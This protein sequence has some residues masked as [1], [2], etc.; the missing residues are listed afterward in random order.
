MNAII[1]AFKALVESF[2]SDPM[3]TITGGNAGTEF[4]LP[5]ILFLIIGLIECLFGLKLLRLE[6]L[7]F[8]FGAGFFLGNMIAG[9]DA[10][11]GLLSADWMKY[12]LMAVLGILCTIIAYKFLRLALLLG[13]AA[14]VFFV[15][16]PILGEV[17]ASAL[18]GKIA[19]G[20]IG[21]VLGLIARKLLKTVVI[22]V[23]AFLGAYLVAY[24]LSGFLQLYILRVPFVT[25]IAL[26][27]F[28]VIGLATQA[29][30]VA[31]K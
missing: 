31:R 2:T 10:V 25:A 22:L 4:S 18:I 17:L 24:A 11:A 27:V 30:G 5:V 29:K 16:G 14:A 3:G 1:S 15:L 20:A 26:A 8:G 19:A 6:L 23:T 7:V 21:L 28:F 13:V 12:V 9:I